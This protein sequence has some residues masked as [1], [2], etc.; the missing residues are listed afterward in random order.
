[1][2]SIDTDY[3]DRDAQIKTDTFHLANVHEDKCSSLL[4]T[5]FFGPL[6]DDK[7]P[8]SGMGIN[9]LELL[10]E[11]IIST[12]SVQLYLI[13]KAI[14]NIS[15]WP[16]YCGQHSRESRKYFVQLRYKL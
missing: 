11:T 8:Y 15:R 4:R 9:E 14:S 2:K 13:P 12:W 7:A 16:Y 5:N 6:L 10:K 1:M 3:T